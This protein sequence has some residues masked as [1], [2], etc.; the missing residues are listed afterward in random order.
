[1]DH[2]SETAPTYNLLDWFLVPRLRNGTDLATIRRIAEELRD[3]PALLRGALSVLLG[4][5]AALEAV[6][7]RSSPHANGFA[8]VI[9]SRGDG[10]TLRLHVWSPSVKSVGG[11]LDPHGHRWAFASWIITGTLREITFVEDRRGQVFLRC[12]YHHDAGQPWN[13]H[14]NGRTTLVADK[15]VDRRAGTVYGRTGAEVHTA[16]PRS[17]LVATLV[18]QGPHRT[19]TTEVFLAPDNLG[20]LDEHEDETLAVDDLRQLVADVLA[21]LP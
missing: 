15:Q 3:R 12:D 19:D 11:N 17:D 5:D 18:L 9:L 10:W 4:N 16:V 7:T 14:G 21:K 1:M 6:A 8:K 13:L 2:S 20:Q